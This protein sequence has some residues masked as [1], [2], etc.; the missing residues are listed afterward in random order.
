MNR[1][2]ACQECV[3]DYSCLLQR[4]DDIESCEDVR[5]YDLDQTEDE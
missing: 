3:L 5:E 1:H 4:D 2:P